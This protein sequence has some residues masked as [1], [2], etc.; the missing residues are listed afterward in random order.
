MMDGAPELRVDANRGRDS[1]RVPSDDDLVD[2]VARGQHH[3]FD[4][5]VARYGGRIEGFLRHVL[6]DASSAED[7]TQ[8]VFLKILLRARDRDPGT[9]FEVWL[10][11]VARREA[12][13]HLRRRRIH[14]R[15]FATLRDRVSGF[16]RNVPPMRSLEHDEFQRDLE[17]AIDLLP[18]DQRDV[19]VLREREEL[20]YEEIAIVV[21]IPAKTVSTRLFRARA[22]LREALRHHIETTDDGASTPNEEDDEVDA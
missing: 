16:M 20:S 9:R 1:L 22:Q 13:D 15:V 3:A 10:F 21:G 7:L 8:E 17:R 14:E 11:C 18:D 4:L 6:K 19:F 2:R 5:L 12:L